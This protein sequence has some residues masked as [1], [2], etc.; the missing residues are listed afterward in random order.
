MKDATKGNCIMDGTSATAAK[1]LT[2]KVQKARMSPDLSGA[3]PCVK[4]ILKAVSNLACND[5]QQNVERSGNVPGQFW[6]KDHQI[7]TTVG[8]D[9]FGPVHHPSSEQPPHIDAFPKSQNPSFSSQVPGQ[10]QRCLSQSGDFPQRQDPNY[11]NCSSQ[12]SGYYEKQPSHVGGSLP[13]V[14]NPNGLD[15][16]THPRIPGNYDQ[17]PHQTFHSPLSPNYPNPNHHPQVPG[18]NNQPPYQSCPLPQNPNFGYKI[19][20]FYEKQPYQSDAFP[21]HQDPNYQSQNPVH[22]EHKPL[23]TFSQPCDSGYETQIL[24]NTENQAKFPSQGPSDHLIYQ[25]KTRN[26]C[27]R[28]NSQENL[29]TVHESTPRDQCR[30]KSILRSNSFGRRLPLT[31]STC[32]CDVCH[33]RDCTIFVMLRSKGLN[34]DSPIWKFFLHRIF[35]SYGQIM[36]VTEQPRGIE[37]R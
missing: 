31:Y 37:V 29:S 23:Q 20:G 11:H 10:Y 12:I 14:H 35:A 3:S 15:R 34:T 6:T 22:S 5:T 9:Q 30:N 19:S 8:G 33:K 26:P 21:Q 18:H 27:E 1:M 7:M 17:P 36:A 2:M 28:H 13:W 16:Y 4:D 32:S 24:R 25:Q